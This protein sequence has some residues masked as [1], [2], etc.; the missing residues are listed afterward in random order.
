MPLDHA[1]PFSREHLVLLSLQIS[2]GDEVYDEANKSHKMIEQTPHL[3]FLR[4][5]LCE[6]CSRILSSLLSLVF[7]VLVPDFQL[8]LHYSICRLRRK[9]V[10]LAVRPTAAI[11]ARRSTS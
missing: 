2:E 4:V 8:G 11:R 6:L 7:C 1:S 5:H 3:S 10:F 9:N